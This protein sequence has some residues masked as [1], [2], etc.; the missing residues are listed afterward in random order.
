MRGGEEGGGGGGGGGFSPKN[1]VGHLGIE[2]N[3]SA[4]LN[5]RLHNYFMEVQ[6]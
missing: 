5:P 2:I 6:G 4:T 3:P 1:A